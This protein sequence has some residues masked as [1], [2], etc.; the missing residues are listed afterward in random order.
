MHN[1]RDHIRITRPGIQLCES[2][3]VQFESEIGASLPKDY[4]RFL[5]TYNGG[6]CSPK[7]FDVPG[8]RGKMTCVDEFSP[9]EPD[10]DY[11]LRWWRRELDELPPE[12]LAIAIDP[13]GNKVLI[14][15]AGPMRGNVWYWYTDQQWVDISGS[16]YKL[17]ESFNEFLGKLYDPK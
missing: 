17:A 1:A 10:A 6:K 8:W 9:L 2:E 3:I 16:M 5:L 15:I 4:R 14:T 13:F 11:S 12:H 7:A